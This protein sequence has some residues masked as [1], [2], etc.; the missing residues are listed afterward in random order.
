[1]SLTFELLLSFV[2]GFLGT[3]ANERLKAL[4]Q[5]EIDWTELLSLAYQHGVIPHLYWKLHQACPEALPKA[6]LHQLRE[7]FDANLRRNLCLTGELL[8]VLNLLEA[9]GIPAIPLK[10]PVLAISLYGNLALRQFTD[11]DI[12]VRKPDVL[13]AK[14]LLI[15]Q[16]YRP[17]YRLNRIQEAV[18]LRNSNHY[19]LYREDPWIHLEIHWRMDPSDSVI[20]LDWEGLWERCEPLALG[21]RTV[22]HPPPEDLLLILGVHG[23]CHHFWQSLKWLCDVAQLLRV[24]QDM[25][26]NRV[27]AG[28]TTPLGHRIL[29]P[30]LILAQDLLGAPLPEEVRRTVQQDPETRRLATWMKQRLFR[31]SRLETWEQTLINL[32]MRERWR[33]RIAYGLDRLLT[34][35][36][37]DWTWIWLPEPLFPLYY[38]LRPI[39]LAVK[40]TRKLAKFV[41]G[42]KDVT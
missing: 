13:K 15:S 39:R 36:L 37:A 20:S 16:S 7:Q 33:D 8:Q 14:E 24:H 19:N 10:G 42:R 34:P 30:G 31:G 18:C 29:G 5:E 23:S 38:L 27:M 21:G 1:M 6:V 2:R 4:L 28:M 22:L 35:N 9:H 41:D 17:L 40:Y 12:L 26:W 11:L 25:D 3:E 32:R